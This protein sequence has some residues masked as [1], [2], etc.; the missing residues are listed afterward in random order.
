MSKVDPK[1]TAHLPLKRRAHQDPNQQRRCNKAGQL[2]AAQT[3][4]NQLSNNKTKEIDQ[5]GIA[6]L[7]TTTEARAIL[8][9]PETP[10]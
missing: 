7:R 4:E 6:R 3:D 2:E 10:G 8:P 9:G 1:E 5:P